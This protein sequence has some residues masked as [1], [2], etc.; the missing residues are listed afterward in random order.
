[1]RGQ[2]ADQLLLRRLETFGA[3]TM[4]DD[5]TTSDFQPNPLTAAAAAEIRRL[6]ARIESLER[7]LLDAESR[8]AT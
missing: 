2:M 1:M 3:F 6:A 7:Q 8:Y 5:G 4:Y